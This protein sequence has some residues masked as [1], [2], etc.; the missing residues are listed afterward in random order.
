MLAAVVAA[1]FQH[2]DEAL[3]IGVDIGVRMRDRMA[4]AGLRREMHDMRK[5]VV[6]E[7]RRRR[8]AVG[9][10]E[11]DEV[12][13]VGLREFGAPRFL[14]RGIVIGRHDVDAD[15]AAALRQQP[16]RHM[17]ADEAGGA[18]DE[19]RCASHHSRHSSIPAGF[20][21]AVEHRACT[22][23]TSALAVAQQAADQRPAAL[24][25]FVMRDGEDHRVGGLERLAG[26]QRRCRIRAWPRPADASGSCTCTATPAAPVRAR[27]RRL[28]NCGCP[29]HFP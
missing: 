24:D 29:A 13:M 8:V 12:E 2:I 19:D 28:S 10:I 1:A 4:H 26:D 22:S 27:Y 23:K 3:Q 18:G 21:R 7:Q 9:E 5:F 16:P 6:L 17:K 25:I 20:D 14:Q 11:L 15:H